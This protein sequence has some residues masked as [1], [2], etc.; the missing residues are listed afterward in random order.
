MKR[1][2]RSREAGARARAD[3]YAVGE[4]VRAARSIALRGFELRKRQAD[5][6]QRVEAAREA[7]QRIDV[8]ALEAEL[9][10]ALAE[11]AAIADEL[12]TLQEPSE[13][14]PP[15]KSKAGRKAVAAEAAAH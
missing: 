14:A 15:E 11:Q 3:L 6:D 8:A 10:A 7:L 4:E 13:P 1:G 9:A 12:S 2:F 5:A